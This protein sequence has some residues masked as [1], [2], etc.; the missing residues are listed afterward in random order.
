MA[1]IV[2]NVTEVKQC[3]DSCIN[4]PLCVYMLKTD[5]C[6]SFQF[7]DSINTSNLTT[8]KGKQNKIPNLDGY[9]VIIANKSSVPSR[10]L[11]DFNLCSNNCTEATNCLGFTGD[12][13]TCSY[14]LQ[15]L[16][17]N[18]QYTSGYFYLKNN[19]DSNPT[20]LSNN[21][22]GLSKTD[23]GAIVIGSI[24][25][26]LLFIW[27]FVKCYKKVKSKNRRGTAIPS[28]CYSK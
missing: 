18:G 28:C 11:Y 16:N 1:G 9:N 23:I 26:S 10:D 15:D 22:S 13:F 19:N 27:A 14:V 17:T 2:R 12:S 25:F 24:V 8:G 4:D 6:K 3:K 20:T 7:V 21:N 5:Y